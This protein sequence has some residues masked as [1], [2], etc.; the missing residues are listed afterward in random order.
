M[1]LKKGATSRLEKDG[2]YQFIETDESTSMRKQCRNGNRFKQESSI[3]SVSKTMVGTTDSKNQLVECKT[4]LKVG[5]MTSN[6]K[7]VVPFVIE[8]VPN[9]LPKIGIGELTIKFE[10]GHQKNGEIDLFY[11]DS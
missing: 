4:Y 1:Q 8:W 6:P 2:T 10:F 9:L 3:N 11:E 7:H 5:N